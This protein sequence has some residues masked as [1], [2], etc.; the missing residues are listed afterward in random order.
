MRDKSHNTGIT[1]AI[2]VKI[3][4]RENVKLGVEDA[5]QIILF[6]KRIAKITVRKY[7]ENNEE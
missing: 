4:E 5:V 1:P 2:I 7:L 3:L 6:L